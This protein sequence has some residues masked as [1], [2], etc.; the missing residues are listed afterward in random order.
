MDVVVHAHTIPSIG[1]LTQ[2]KTKAQ[3]QLELDSY[4]DELMYIA[5]SPDLPISTDTMHKYVASP[6]T[7]KTM[8]HMLSDDLDRGSRAVYPDAMKGRV[9]CQMDVTAEHTDTIKDYRYWH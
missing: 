4:F 5:T 6:D 1:T 2:A 3:V 8:M 7:L 9:K